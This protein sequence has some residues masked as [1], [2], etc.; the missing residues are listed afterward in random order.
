MLE[1]SQAVRMFQAPPLACCLLAVEDY[2]HCKAFKIWNTEHI[3][4]GK[5]Y[6]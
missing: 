6:E 5:K 4:G 1:E 3:D 2:L